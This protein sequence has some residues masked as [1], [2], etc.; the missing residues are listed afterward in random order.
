M[1]T[2]L[3]GGAF[4]VTLRMRKGAAKCRAFLLCDRFLLYNGGAPFCQNAY[5][6]PAHSG[7]CRKPIL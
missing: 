7:I 4:V 1:N 6:F 5:P 3:K 2:H